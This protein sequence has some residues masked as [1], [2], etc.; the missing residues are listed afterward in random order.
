MAKSTKYAALICVVL[1][2]VAAA[3]IAA[4]IWKSNVYLVIAGMLP[5]VIYEI[6]R[7][8]GVTTK[9]ASIGMLAVL[10]ALC[11]M[12]A[13]KISFNLAPFLAKWGI[14]FAVDAKLAGPV[15]I[16]VLAVI[17]LRQTAGI[18]TK[19]LAIIIFVAAIALFYVLD[20]SIFSFLLKRG[21]EEGTKRI[22]K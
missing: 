13:M 10:V 5:A 2:I 15:I 14:S 1:T 18:Y 8:E 6:Y 22:P 7:T 12:I 16:A 21:V 4:G 3:G 9:A 20:P 11:V 19:W 17:L